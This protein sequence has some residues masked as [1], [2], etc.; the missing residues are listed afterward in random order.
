MKKNYL[1]IRQ[2]SKLLLFSMLFNLVAA[3]ISASQTEEIF[4]PEDIKVYNRLGKLHLPSLSKKALAEEQE[5]AKIKEE[6]SQKF[7]DKKI[8]EIV[9]PDIGEIEKLKTLYQIF[10]ASEALI[11]R[12][13]TLGENV[14]SDLEILCGD[15][16]SPENHILKKIDN[17]ETTIGKIELQKMIF[18][19][20]SDIEKLKKRQAIIKELVSNEDLAN[21][22]EFEVLKLKTTENELIWFWRK[23]EEEINAYF[24]QVYFK[25]AESNK[26]VGKLEASF[27][28]QTVGIP[29]VMA[30][31]PFI[32][33]AMMSLT[34]LMLGVPPQWIGEA[35][36]FFFVETF[37]GIG[38]FYNSNLLPISWKISA[39]LFWGSIFF[40][41]Y[42]LPIIVTCKN[43]VNYNAVTNLI[44]RR[45]NNIATFN[46]SL[47]NINVL[48]N[49]NEVFKNNFGETSKLIALNS[50]KEEEAKELVKNLQTATFKGKPSFFSHKGKVL[51]TF[52]MMLDSKTCFINAMQAAGQIDA[53]LSI[54]KLYKKFANNSNATYCLVQ[55][56]NQQ[57]P[58]VKITDFWHPI[59]NP[60]TVVTNSIE[61]GTSGGHKDVILTGPNAGGK[62]TALKA[63]TLAIILGQ[64]LGIAPAKEMTL[65]PFAQINTYLNIADREGK[66]SLFQAE[67]HRAQ[68]LLNSIRMLRGND[69]SFVI[70][71]EIFTGTNPTEGTAGAYGIAKNLS[72]YNNSICIVA[73]H[74]HK[75]TDLEQD[76]N[77]TFKNYKV[78]VVK[79]PDGTITYPYKL[80]FGKTDQN[81]A[82]QLLQNEG[83]D[84]DII[85]DAQ[86]VMDSLEKQKP[87][88]QTAANQPSLNS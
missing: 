45:M 56:V 27:L 52:K 44:Q 86:A 31:Y 23:L 4:N 50:A 46:T 55:Y 43:S 18:N 32:I 60:N 53:M 1:R 69:F 36:E 28:W 19:P 54:A 42:V 20:T 64:A 75:L 6:N 80:E 61:L 68:L 88:T 17:T 30:G 29:T 7:K 71:D 3:T 12:Q 38:A 78:N 63:I 62:S 81:I 59:L 33:G 9:V 79:Y 11:K 66:E 77:G 49:S 10:A 48:M 57:K 35:W 65:T 74:Y 72:K 21:K 87:Q 41:S 47:R 58:Y 2:F 85:Q 8:K 26:E 84:Y 25:N 22:L 37:E 73:T 40:V 16:Q 70:M 67:M 5:L 83:F 13:E 39:T 51:A 82:L 76:T 15:K 34:S 14:F 24:E